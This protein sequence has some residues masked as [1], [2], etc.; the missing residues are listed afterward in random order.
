MKHTILLV[1]DNIDLGNLLTSYLD[2]NDFN[3]NWC[4][5]AE[6]ALDVFGLNKF[7]LCIFDIMLP[8]MNGFELSE[9]LNNNAGVPFI[10]L[11]ARNQ[12]EDRIKGLSIGA[13]DYICKPFEPEEL[14]LRIK[15]IL[16]RNNAIIEDEIQIGKYLFSPSELRLKNGENEYKL[17][18]KEAELLT[19]FIKNKN[20]PLDREQ[21]LVD[22]WG[23]NDYFIGR[24]LDVFIS[25][26]RKYLK[27]DSKLS[28]K[29]IRGKGFT[30][31]VNY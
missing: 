3:T 17:T 30:F 12:K 5:S 4:K 13:D 9:K 20:R 27:S 29:T 28:I 21:I 6:E 8:G 19:Y 11:T 7:D 18:I 2:I 10:F 25:R 1:E 16:K 15:N 22:L 31:K 14:L 26:L 23:E 24:S